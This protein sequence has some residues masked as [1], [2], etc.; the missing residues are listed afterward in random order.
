MSLES[1]KTEWDELSKEYSN[2]EVS[3]IEND[4][5]ILQLK[6][7]RI[8]FYC[9]WQN[10]FLFHKTGCEQ[11]ICRIAGETWRITTKMHERHCS[12]AISYQS[13]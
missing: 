7:S 13:D 10:Y 6:Q 12:P 8:L 2:L 5:E 9:K 1:I 3:E 11:R 4:I